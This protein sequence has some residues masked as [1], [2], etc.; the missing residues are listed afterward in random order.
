[1]QPRPKVPVL[2]KRQREVLQALRDGA[3]ITVDSVNTAWLG[4]QMLHPL[5]R[6]FLTQN[7]FIERR[8]KTKSVQTH[9]N[10]FVISAKGIVALDASVKPES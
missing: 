8:D 2:K 1:M 9:S 10:G 3:L 6:Y 4:T 5:T 7:R